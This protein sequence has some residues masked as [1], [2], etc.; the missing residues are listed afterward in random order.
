MQNMA[1]RVWLTFRW[2]RERANALRYFRILRIV[3]EPL[4]LGLTICPESVYI[5]NKVARSRVHVLRAMRHLHDFDGPGG[6]KEFEVLTD[7]SA[8]YIQIGSNRGK[9]ADEAKI[10]RERMSDDAGTEKE[11]A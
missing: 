8:W 5:R 4:K 1:G 7:A 3:F 10:E 2:G 9:Y 11:T 6:E